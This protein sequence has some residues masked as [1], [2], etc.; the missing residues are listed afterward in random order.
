[1]IYARVHDQTVADDYYTAMS[2]VEKRLDLFGTQEDTSI[3]IGDDERSLLL[4]LTIQ[5]KEPEL[6]LDARLN[7]IAQMCE[8]LAC[9]KIDPP[10]YSFSAPILVE[11]DFA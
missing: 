4:K 5:L 2:Q 3:S 9:P 11:A 8:M 10:V 7:I 1:M 6:N